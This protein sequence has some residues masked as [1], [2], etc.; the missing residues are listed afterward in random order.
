[1]TDVSFSTIGAETMRQYWP[2]FLAGAVVQGWLVLYGRRSRHFPVR[3]IAPTAIVAALLAALLGMESFLH[4]QLAYQTVGEGARADFSRELDAHL[5]R[6]WPPLAGV[7][8][9]LGALARQPR[10]RPT[11]AFLTAGTGVLLSWTVAMW[12]FVTNHGPLVFRV[13]VLPGGLGIVASVVGFAAASAAWMATARYVWLR[14][15][16]RRS[17]PPEVRVEVVEWPPEP[18]RALPEGKGAHHEDGDR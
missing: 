17:V 5:S 10:S 11:T 9:L 15:R 12:L 13:L 4:T 3:W 16:S 8:V 1:M 7:A 18:R 6:S 2:I 14:E